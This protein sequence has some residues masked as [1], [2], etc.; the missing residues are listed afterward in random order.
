MWSSRDGAKHKVGEKEL[1]VLVLDGAVRLG[2]QK[3]V[4]RVRNKVS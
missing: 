4:G 2:P 3:S 1:E